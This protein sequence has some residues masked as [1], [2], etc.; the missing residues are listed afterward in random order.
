LIG[1]VGGSVLS[2]FLEHPDFLAFKI[3]ALVRNS[4]K[5]EKLRALGINAVMGSHSDPSLMENLAAESDVVVRKWI[6]SDRRINC[7]HLLARTAQL[8]CCV[9]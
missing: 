9:S 3:T 6:S 1:Y 4:E 8:M 7:L 2:R 5:A